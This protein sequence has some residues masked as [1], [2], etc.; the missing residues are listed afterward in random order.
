MRTTVKWVTWAMA[1]STL[2]LTTACGT[3]DSSTTSEQPSAVASATGHHSASPP[4]PAAPL[5]SGERFR[6]LSMPTAYTPDPPSGGTDE[7]RCFLVNPELTKPTYLTGSQFIPQNA[8]IVHHAIFYRVD[9]GQVAEA[10]AL[11]ASEKGEGWRC[12]G[13]T[14]I[15]GRGPSAQ[16][17]QGN[18]WVA[19][20]AP[21]GHEGLLAP[22][23]GYTLAAGSQL[24]MQVHYNLLA[25]N[26]KAAGSDK[27]S[28]RLRLREGT[29]KVDPLQTRLVTAPIELPCAPGESGKFCNRDAAVF[30]VIK[31]FGP[32]A[33]ATVAGL[34]LICDKGKPWK[35][36]PTQSCDRRISKPGYVQ[37][38][39]GHMHLLGRSIKVELNAGTPKAQTLLDV[40]TYDF[41][42]QGARP[43][44]KPVAVKAGDTYRV[45]CTYDATLR[46]KLPQLKPLKPRYV[47]WGDGTADEMCL[48]V[49]V[50]SN[51]P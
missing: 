30:D 18:S 28:I 24:V 46:R 12:F 2:V 39:A 9:P 31:R 32:E 10:K 35:P 51:T 13:G 26:G 3:S 20:W 16:L 19:A 47:V 34:H 14:G 21:G 8:D 25:T 33:G 22:G 23:K 27:S 49:V 37:A 15:G 7:Y 44:A 50:W 11:D 45:T 4:P 40:K 41:D 6:F 48:G 1:L 42:D 36:G 29:A 5:R 17:S 38:V 43:L